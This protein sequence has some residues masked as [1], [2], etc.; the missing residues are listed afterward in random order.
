MIH[1]VTKQIPADNPIRILHKNIHGSINLGEMTGIPVS[2]V[3]TN[4]SGIDH[5]E[6]VYRINQGDWQMLGLTANGNRFYGN[7]PI[8]LTEVPQTVEY[9]IS[10]TS[11]NGKTITKPITASQGGYFTF[12]YNDGNPEFDS[13][14]FDFDTEPMPMECITFPFGSNWITEDTTGDQPTTTGI[15]T[16]ADVSSQQSDVWYSLDG[17]KLSRRPTKPGV[18]IHCGKKVVLRSGT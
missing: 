14:M 13:T 3:I 10:A 1:C 7:L 16:M 5:A 2:A 8:S 15:V 11:N 18:Y 12:T 4:R 9:Y 17:R 6:V